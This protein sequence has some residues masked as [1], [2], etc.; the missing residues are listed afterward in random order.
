MGL[1]EA[2][3][4][5]RPKVSPTE[6]RYEAITAYAPR[7][8]S[9]GG[10]IYENELVRAAVDAK[11][12]H[13]GKLRFDMFGPA[14]AKLKTIVKSAPNP[15][16]TWPQFLERSSNI[17][18]VENNLFVVPI[19]DGPYREITGFYPVLPS[20]CEVVQGA[21]G[22]PFLK[23]QF[24]NGKVQSLP[25]DQVAIVSRHQ[26]KD[27]FFGERN[28]TALAGTME[29]INMVNQ[30]IQEG[31]KNS[32]TFRFMAQTTQYLFDDD[33]TKERNRFNRLSFQGGNGGLL[34]FN[35]NL[36]NIQQ[37]KQ[38][39]YKVDPEQMKMIRENV[40][41]YFGVNENILQNKAQGDDLDAFFNGCIEPFAIKLSDALTRIVYTQ[42]ERNNGNHIS[43]TAN[44]LQYM[45]VSAK[46]NMATQLGD[47]GCLT[48]DEIRELFNYA[49]LPD[50]A[51][52]YAPIRGEYKNVKDENDE[53]GGD[54]D[55]QQG[56]G[57]SNDAGDG[58]Q[59][60]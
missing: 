35:N 54:T 40:Y 20:T 52:T 16:Q 46:V 8:T 59:E 13:I 60:S 19:L 57:V 30:G 12:R 18:D 37:I 48:I 1:I 21:D 49:P 38:D 9:W 51:G 28:E 7:F 33:L 43:F 14:H 10:R 5:R 23:F 36:Q 25:L 27:D 11:A 39:A 17:Y 24:A 50:G 15:W 42:I 31:V 3:F 44:R 47:R 26:L 6:G 22:R 58:D 45:N 41:S 4:G 55:A 56:T 53:N 32:A 2:I 29:L 34:L